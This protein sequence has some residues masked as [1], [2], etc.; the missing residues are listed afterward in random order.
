MDRDIPQIPIR[1]NNERI[2]ASTIIDVQPNLGR[3]TGFQPRP[4]IHEINLPYTSV[5]SDRFNGANSILPMPLPN[6]TS[7]GPQIVRLPQIP[8]IPYLLTKLVN[9]NNNNSINNNRR[10]QTKDTNKKIVRPVINKNITIDEIAAVLTQDSYYRK[11][12]QWPLI[13]LKDVSPINLNRKVNYMYVAA[14]HNKKMKCNHA[15]DKVLDDRYPYIKELLNTFKGHLVACGGAIVKSIFN[16]DDN[17]VRGDI[18]IFFYDLDIENANIVRINALEFLIN[19]YQNSKDSDTIRI[20]VKRNQYTTTLQITKSNIDIV[21]YQFI[22]RIYPD[23][24]SIIGGFDLSICMIAYDGADVYATPLGAWSL[25]NASII[26][27]TKRRS[28]SFEHRLIKYQNYGFRL[29]FPGI[30]DE[31]IRNFYNNNVEYLSM[32]NKIEQIAKDY[33]YDCNFY[34]RDDDETFT[35]KYPGLPE[36]KMFNIQKKEDVLPYFR[37]YHHYI[38][39]QPYD[40]DI[41]EDR[42]INKIS[43]YSSISSLPESFSNINAKQLRSDNLHAVHSILEIFQG[44]DVR[45]LLENDINDPN[46]M[47]DDSLIADYYEKTDQ[48]RKPYVFFGNEVK[49]KS[50]DFYRLVRY[51]GKL[52]PEVIK[53]RDTDEYYKY[54]DI[55]I[56]KM[57][58]N[59]N[60]CQENLKSINWITKNPGRQWTSSIN[61]IIEDPREWYGKH[62]IPVVTGIPSDIETTLRLM[63]LPQTESIWVNINDDIF[64]IICLHLLKLYS[65]DAWYY[66]NGFRI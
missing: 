53:I 18:D 5:T 23:I 39:S 64:S 58:T 35:F 49:A 20:H 46:I 33:G 56:D 63:R 44:Y 55:M 40:R 24:S 8:Q 29:I 26:I 6:S 25:K 42:L 51:F 12:Q 52:T 65:D 16:N 3:L 15:Y 2:D 22:H 38:G 14:L 45:C 47:M 31:F 61:P 7:D 11:L 30:S 36:L 27:D 37:L 41:I 13:K 21:E 28:T 10:L 50:L 9:N 54:R 19:S 1:K 43:D 34:S 57:I 17:I 59:T 62:Y 4:R 32:I 60:K 48:A 66:I